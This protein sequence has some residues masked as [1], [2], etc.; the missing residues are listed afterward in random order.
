M[1][2]ANFGKTNAVS[3]CK[4]S[5]RHIH[6]LHVSMIQLFVKTAF[7]L[8]LRLFDSRFVALY[9]SQ[10]LSQYSSRSSVTPKLPT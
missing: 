6:E 3:F 10:E 8:S 5:E 1:S 7:P 2:K 9:T 4:M